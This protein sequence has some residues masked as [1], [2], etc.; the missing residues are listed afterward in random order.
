MMPAQKEPIQYST[1][2]GST[3]ISPSGAETLNSTVDARYDFLHRVVDRAAVRQLQ[4]HLLLK[5]IVVT[6]LSNKWSPG[7]QTR[8]QLLH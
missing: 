7:Q 3:L 6:S 5:D 4:G 1:K 2:A 8:K